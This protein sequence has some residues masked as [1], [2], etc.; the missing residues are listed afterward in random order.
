[1]EKTITAC[2]II[3]QKLE[4]HQ[5]YTCPANYTIASDVRYGRSLRRKSL[6]EPCDGLLQGFLVGFLNLL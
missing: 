2:K 5:E 1:M 3:A 6:L 4:I